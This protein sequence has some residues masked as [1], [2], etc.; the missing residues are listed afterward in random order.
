MWS[1]LCQRDSQINIPL[2]PLP[3]TPDS[4]SCLP[5]MS[6]TLGHLEVTVNGTCLDQ[7]SQAS[8]PILTSGIPVLPMFQP[9]TLGPDFS[10]S[11]SP[12]LQVVKKLCLLYIKMY[13]EFTIFYEP[14]C[15]QPIQSTT[16]PHLD[17][18][19]GLSDST[20]FLGLHSAQQPG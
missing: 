5:S 10:L 20:L 7:S 6:S 13:P 19:S 15:H 8:F 12:H 16:V 11:L 9:R 3:G 1:A 14:H 17:C 4:P 2:R 18:C